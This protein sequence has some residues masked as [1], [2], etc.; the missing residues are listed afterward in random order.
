[1]KQTVAL[2][3][4]SAAV[5]VLHGLYAGVSGWHLH[6]HVWRKAA[7]AECLLGDAS[8]IT[9]ELRVGLD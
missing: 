6:L 1:M 4:T 2:I 7:E 3:E 9:V 8:G 5:D